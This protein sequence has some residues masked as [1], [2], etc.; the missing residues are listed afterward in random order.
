MAYPTSPPCPLQG[1]GGKKAK[2]VQV[3]EDGGPSEVVTSE[4][5]TG[6][7][8]Q[9]ASSLVRSTGLGAVPPTEGAAHQNIHM[10]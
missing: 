5:T 8:M 7:S 4:T 10:S 3:A 9:P 6:E 1:G 2:P